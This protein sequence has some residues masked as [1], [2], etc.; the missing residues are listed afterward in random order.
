[1]CFD[2][3]KT[4]FNQKLLLYNVEIG[5]D[6]LELAKVNFSLIK[7]QKQ[8]SKDEI[9]TLNIFNENEIIEMFDYSKYG[10][11]FAFWRFFF[12]RLMIKFLY[13]KYYYRDLNKNADFK[14]SGQI[15]H[16]VINKTEKGCPYIKNTLD[17]QHKKGDFPYLSISYTKEFII[18]CLGPK[19]FGID[20]ETILQR[21]NS[22]IEKN[23]MRSELE[24]FHY[25][26]SK[27]IKNNP[28]SIPTI[29]WTIKEAT[30]KAKS[31]KS[32]SE[33]KKIQIKYDKNQ[34][35]SNFFDGSET[36]QNFINLSEDI[37][38][39]ISILDEGVRIGDVNGKTKN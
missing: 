10:K 34:I 32:L 4:V 9:R 29:L 11:P 24:G 2:E 20:C 12:S 26:L 15:K 19:K 38:I 16:F 1:M 25:Q 27:E 7:N 30:L 8:L 17:D 35:L 23:F 36:F 31:D 37:I 39:S 13:F 21:S 28:F 6:T 3:E 14:E 18:V 5:E 33:I 22:W